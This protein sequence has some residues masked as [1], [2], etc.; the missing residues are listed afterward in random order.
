[1]RRTLKPLNIG[2]HTVNT[3]VLLAPM[4]SITDKP[5]R[6]IC[7]RYGAGMVVSEM[8]AS[9]AVVRDSVVSAQK[10]EYD[11]EQGIHSVQ[12][13]GA[14]PKNM[15]AAA[16]ANREIGADIIDINMGC[17]VKKVVNCMAGSALLKDEGLVG[18]I[19]EATAEAVD[20][21]V[22]LKTRL[23]WSDDMKN[24]PRVARLAESRGIKMLAIHGRT[25]A[26]MYNGSADWK[27]IREI[28]EA[29]SIPV[30]VNGDIIT[31]SDA[32]QAL[33]D[34]NCDGVMIG[35]ACQGRPWF[36]G[37]V[38][39]Y[40]KHGEILPDPAVDE[41]YEIVRDHYD[42]AIAFY[43]EQRGVRLMRKHMAWYTKGFRD[44][45]AYRRLV[46]NMDRADDVRALTHDYYQRWIEEGVRPTNPHLAANKN[47]KEEVKA[48]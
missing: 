29:V 22:T 20:V 19:L 3:P 12:L 2:P 9:E 11:P 45:A 31:L 10:A 6:L 5:F 16:K 25:R 23:G 27:A 36:L 28:K 33:E 13:V 30:L 32:V 24:G 37:Q 39:Y 44:G 14:D 43:G 17:P 7:K 47:K 8:I 48:A 21:P 4:T 38:A 34:S 41:Q 46:N 40:L 26:Q 35:R 18:D 1:M 42:M 15:A